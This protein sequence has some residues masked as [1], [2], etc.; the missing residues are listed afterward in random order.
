[1]G[2]IVS[3]TIG[4]RAG[5]YAMPIWVNNTN[6]L[7]EELADDNSTLALGLGTRLRLSSSLYV[8][9]EIMPRLSGNDPGASHASVAIEAR[10]GGH[11]FQINFSNGFGTT[12]AQMA[13][14]GSE[15]DWYIGFN[16]SRKFF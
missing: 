14:G 5:F 7:P 3:T 2:A 16:I 8:V 6:E 13:R 4:K 15:D 9:A 11:A 1:V 12:M 10:K